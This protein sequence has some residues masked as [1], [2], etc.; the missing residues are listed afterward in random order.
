LEVTSPEIA[1]ISSSVSGSFSFANGSSPGCCW[2]NSR[3]EAWEMSTP[4]CLP[5]VGEFL[6]D[7]DHEQ[8]E[9]PGAPA[10]L[11]DPPGGRLALQRLPCLVD[12]QELFP[13][14]GP[15]CGPSRARYRSRTR[16]ARRST[17]STITNSAAGT[18]F[19]GISVVSE[20]PSFAAY[21]EFG[22]LSAARPGELDALRWPWVRLEDDEVDIR[23]QWNVK[24]RKFTEP[25]YGP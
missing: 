23:E 17:L 11:P 16:A 13:A 20:P 21:L 15:C 25:K 5:V 3:I 24:A 6:A 18:C 19:S 7:R 22:C 1:E 4:A 14:H 10:E 8:R 12:G 9:V 2:R